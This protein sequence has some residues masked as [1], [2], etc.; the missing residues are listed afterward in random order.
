MSRRV[1]DM[2]GTAFCLDCGVFAVHERG[3]GSPL[4]IRHLPTCPQNPAKEKTMT[5][6]QLHEALEA[7]IKDLEAEP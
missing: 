6:D 4:V 2:T 1:R 7:S 3:P 5:V